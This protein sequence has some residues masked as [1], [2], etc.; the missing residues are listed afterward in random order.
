LTE[1]NILLDRGLLS[2]LEAE[3]VKINQLIS[4]E[5]ILQLL[6]RTKQQFGCKFDQ[7]YDRDGA[8]NLTDN[9]PVTYNPNQKDTDR[10][11]IWDV[12]DDDI[13]ADMISNPIWL[14]D[15]AGYF[16]LPIIFASQWWSW[17]ILSGIVATVLSDN[18]PNIHNPDQK[19]SDGDGIGDVCESNELF[20]MYVTW[21]PL[22]GYP[23]LGV[24]FKATLQGNYDKI[25]W[26]FD[27]ESQGEGISPTHVYKVPGL[28]IVRVFAYRKDTKIGGATLTVIV[29]DKTDYALWFQA[30]W[31]PLIWYAPLSVW[32]STVYSWVIDTVRRSIDGKNINKKPTEK[33]NY[34]FVTW[35]NYDIV[36]RAYDKDRIVGISK[37]NVQVF[38]SGQMQTW[39]WPVWSNLNADILVCTLGQTIRFDTTYTGFELNDITS[40]KRD[41]WDGVVVTNTSLSVSKKCATLGPNIVVQTITLDD[42]RVLENILN[43]YLISDQSDMWKWSSI[44]ANPLTQYIYQPVR[45]TLTTDN[46]KFADIQVIRC[47]YWDQFYDVYQKGSIPND[48]IFW[49][50]YHQLGVHQTTC[51]L[52]IKDG[53][54]LINQATVQVID[55]IWWCHPSM[56][57]QL[58]CD[59]DD[60]Q[61]PDMCDDDIDGD[62]TPNML[63]LLLSENPPTCIIGSWQIDWVRFDQYYDL[64]QSGWDNDNC[65]FIINADQIDQNINSYGDICDPIISTGLSNTSPSSSWPT[66]PSSSWPT[67]PSSSWPTSPSSSWPTSPSS[68]W[69]TSPSSSWPTSP[70]SSWPTSPSSSWPTS[71]SSSWP[72]EDQD[73]LPDTMD[74]CPELPESFNGLSDQDGCPDMPSISTPLDPWVETQTC[75]VCPC[76]LADFQADIVGWDMI[77]ATLRNKEGWLIYRYSSTRIIDTTDLQDDKP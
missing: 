62:G 3:S 7:D 47:E 44:S 53:T 31:S 29:W 5:K 48:L 70:S 75:I 58:Q 76:P 72:D 42:G 68:S 11:G 55:T 2:V 1:L 36:A 20:A 8:P 69:P 30:L 59:M 38:H 23:P 56:I 51:Y 33:W 4:W 60:D 26:N 39:V 40:V 10:D 9:S 12:S 77:R 16:N 14:I 13:D 65:P 46:V 28:Y 18:C 32:L 71:P 52:Y 61:L 19:D 24:K 54:I 66:S 43:T 25:K 6:Y 34:V 37:L 35:G 41:F 49:H 22:Y 45:Y 50:T 63:W 67:S 73:T 74:Q 27:D 57:S 17:A 64:I 15:D 21:D